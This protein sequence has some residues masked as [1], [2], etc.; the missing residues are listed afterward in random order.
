M[1]QGWLACNGKYIV[2]ND[3]CSEETSH[4]HDRNLKEFM[5]RL[6]AT[7]AQ[8]A[9][10]DV[11]EECSEVLSRSWGVRLL[12]RNH[13]RLLVAPSNFIRWAQYN[14]NFHFLRLTTI[15]GYISKRSE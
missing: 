15:L 5:G 9:T 14:D 12:Q 3:R 11:L 8:A 10:G 13:E 1:I 4:F 7:S 2:D 6:R